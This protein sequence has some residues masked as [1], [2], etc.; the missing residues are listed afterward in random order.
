MQLTAEGKDQNRD[1]IEIPELK[2]QVLI[3]TLQQ[4]RF[5]NF[6]EISSER[7]EFNLEYKN[8]KCNRIIIVLQTSLE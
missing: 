2:G 6:A 1:P 3:I 5:N 4:T 7:D 8:K